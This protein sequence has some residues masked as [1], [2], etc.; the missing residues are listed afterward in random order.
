MRKFFLS[1]LAVFLFS[2]AQAQVDDESYPEDY[3]GDEIKTLFSGNNT[4]GGYGEI[5][6]LYS[7]I[8]DRDAFLFGARGGVLLGH[9]MTI[10]LCGT[11]F[12]N[13]AQY[14]PVLEDEVTLAGGYGGLFFEPILFPKFPVHVTLPVTIGAGGVALARMY[15]ESDAYMVIEPGIEIELN[16]TRFFRFSIGGYYRFT[17]DINLMM[18]D[19]AIP[20]DVLRGFSGGVN[21]KFGRF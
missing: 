12:F 10:G 21:F 8:D 9:M 2:F 18:G 15:E 11:G 4:V 7:Q 14:I 20:D 16:I 13:D 19:R 3:H 5:S 1:A 6:M 17:S